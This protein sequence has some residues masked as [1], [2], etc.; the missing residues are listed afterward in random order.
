MNL[1]G[2][3]KMLRVKEWIKFF[4][5][6]PLIGAILAPATPFVLISVGVIFFCVIAFGFVVNNY[7]DVEI[8]MRNTKKVSRGNNPLSSGRVTK[9][10]T[11]ALM[12]LL[13]AIAIALACFLSPGISGVLFTLLCISLLTLYSVNHIRL[14]E[15]FIVDILTHGLMFGLFPVLAGFTLAGGDLNLNT[16][17]LLIAALFMIVGC[18][19]LLTHQINDYEEDLGYSSTTIVKV[20]L[21]KGWVLLASV[22]LLSIA[23]LE[24]IIHHSDIGLVL[25]SV[26]FAYLIAYPF[27]TCK[28]EIQGVIN[29]TLNC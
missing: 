25:H 19:S 9:R 23:I 15:R 26:A 2:Y 21:K 22:V 20:G 18:E 24:L 7:F 4:A 16:P 12:C 5:P 14:K 6:I 10:G 13:L 28:G 27:Y 8:D 11:F 17:I 1:R 3:L 29:N